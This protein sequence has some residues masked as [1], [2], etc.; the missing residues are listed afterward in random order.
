MVGNLVHGVGRA[1]NILGVFFR[2]AMQSISVE[3]EVSSISKYCERKTDEEVTTF[4]RAWCVITSHQNT[5][6]SSNY[7]CD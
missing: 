1:T 7:S 4:Q 6:F 2:L 5:N 3:I